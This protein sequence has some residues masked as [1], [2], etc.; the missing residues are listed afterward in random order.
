MAER[1]QRQKL[2]QITGQVEDE[3]LSPAEA[4]RII[5]QR[6][7]ALFVPRG[8][9]A[10]SVHRL[11]RH[12]YIH[13]YLPGEIIVPS[14]VHAGCLGLVVRGQVAV[15][16]G[17]RR[18][19]SARVMLLPGSTFGERM[20][21]EGRRSR[22]TLQA[23]TPCEIWFVYRDALEA[24]EVAQ[25]RETRATRLRRLGWGTVGFVAACVV[26]LVLFS[27]SPVRRA[28]AVVPMSLGQWCAQEGHEGCAE[29]A[30]SL[31][32]NL[33]PADANPLLAL[34]TL[35]FEQEKIGPAE[36][37]FE[38]ARDLVPESPE[39]HNNL[40]LI[41]A[42]QG[43]HEQAITDFERAL[44]L[45][46]GVATVEHNLGFSLQA[47]GAYE[48]AVDHYQAALA[49]GET[50]ASTLANMAIAY[51]ESDQPAEAAELAR[52][53]LAL[54]PDLAPAHAILG[55]IAL[56]EQQ[57]DEALAHLQQAVTL[58]DDFCQAYFYLGLAHKSLARPA[59]AIFAFER[60]LATAR[61]EATRVRI[62]RHLNE[63]YQ[64]EEQKNSP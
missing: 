62:R 38:A 53:A 11:A 39:I 33:A 57:P 52:E 13:S 28:V 42:R 43:D 41:H 25:R 16:P 45:E 49:L 55:A 27:L 22:A 47:I 21:A 2:A 48:E 61:D 18:A 7:S 3:G 51:Y 1:G 32:A 54:D 31:G 5:R 37:T 36:Q 23:L 19:A 58:N 20:L 9:E 8:L 4:H 10:N 40:G 6:L 50:E 60:A 26:L 56:D 30:W 24:V 35:Y 17:P 14:G 12:V 64:A 15:Q 29:G 34:G 44:E 59:D 63:L 46:P